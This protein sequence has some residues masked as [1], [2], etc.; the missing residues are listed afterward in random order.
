MFFSCFYACLSFND[1]IAYGYDVMM[2]NVLRP[3]ITIKILTVVASS[4][5]VSGEGPSASNHNVCDQKPPCHV[6]P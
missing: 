4:T 5:A 2:I 1:P 3:C 6:K